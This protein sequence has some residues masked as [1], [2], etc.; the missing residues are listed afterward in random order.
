MAGV[1]RPSE[2]SSPAAEDLTRAADDVTGA[3]EPPASSA[4]L[5]EARRVLGAIDGE[6]GRACLL[7]GDL[8]EVGTFYDV[9]SFLG[10]SRW[11]G[12]LWVESDGVARSLFFDEGHVVAATS[13]ATEDHL[14]AVL[15]RAGVLTEHQVEACLAKQAER[16]LRFG[17][18]AVL[19]G[20]L[21]HE[22]LFAEMGRQVEA[23]FDAV[24]GARTCV[25]CFLLG[26][27]ETRLA[28]RRRH[29][30]DALL[31]DAIRRIDE[32]DRLPP[33]LVTTEHVPTRNLSMSPPTDPLGVYAK[34]DGKLTVAELCSDSSGPGLEITKALLELLQTG[35]VSIAPPRIGP[36]RLVEVYNQAIA[37]LLRELDAMDAG[38]EVRAALARFSKEPRFA[39]LFAGAG[40]ADDGTFD[41]AA[42]AANA[43]ACDDPRAAEEKLGALLYDYASYALFLARPHLD[44]RDAARAAGDRARVSSRVAA[45]LEPLAPSGPAPSEDPVAKAADVEIAWPLVAAT[46]RPGRA[47]ERLDATARQRRV[48]L[49]PFPGIDASRTIR[50]PSVSLARLAA[51]ADPGG[52]TQ[53]LAAAR[54]PGASAPVASPT[55]RVHRAFSPPSP[56]TPAPSPASGSGT[57]AAPVVG[58]RAPK[59]P[60]SPWVF[61]L[62]GAAVAMLATLTVAR[63]AGRWGARAPEAEPARAAT[64]IVVVCEPA[65]EALYVDGALT[66]T[67][68]GPIA[69]AAG[70]HA[71]VAT[72][73]GAAPAHTTVHVADGESRAVVLDLSRR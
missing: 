31:L 52:G 24:V 59:L 39:N 65:C 56:I 22:R 11:R 28:F 66:G 4:R 9:L 69:V 50:M 5:E 63:T 72:R 48:E 29:H 61:A 46:E 3:A 36:T 41:V 68:Q 27:D 19:L 15:V 62:G 21:T 42:I 57:S 37:L 2:P 20:Y 1:E 30:V 40:P 64:E 7:L 58:S 71:I 26:F 54:V 33:R 47:A 12:E 14:G 55:R 53:K 18:V 34:I 13:T 17:E 43:A 49:A 73:P 23:V 35:H 44:R 10:H 16:A 32:T 6:A 38:D 25:F 60:A 51:T 8:G 45:L 70:P 67:R